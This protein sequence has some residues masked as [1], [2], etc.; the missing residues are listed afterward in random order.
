LSSPFTHLFS[1]ELYKPVHGV[2]VVLPREWEAYS[3]DDKTLLAKILGS[4]KLHPAAVQVISRPAITFGSLSNFTPSHVLIFGSETEGMKTYEAVQ[5]QGFSVLKAD[6]LSQL[7]EVRKKSLW[8][9]LKSM[10]GV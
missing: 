9:A 4:V 6:D 2:I 3:A 7:D 8:L 10:F 1:E 5:A